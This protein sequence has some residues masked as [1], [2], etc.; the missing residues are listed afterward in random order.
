MCRRRKFK[1]SIMPCR[2]IRFVSLSRFLRVCVYVYVSLASFFDSAV[3]R[4]SSSIFRFGPLFISCYCIVTAS[5]GYFCFSACECACFSASF[6]GFLALRFSVA[7]FCLDSLITSSYCPVFGIW[8]VIAS[9]RVCLF[10]CLIFSFICSLVLS[11]VLILSSHRPIAL[12]LVFSVCSCFSACAWVC[13]SAS[14][15]SSFFLRLSGCICGLGPLFTSSHCAVT[16]FGESVC[17]FSCLSVLRAS[18]SRSVA[19]WFAGYIFSLNLLI[20]C[21]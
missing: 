14:F 11:F 21:S 4:I 7:I 9:F 20:K 8:C 3:F 13:F 6:S 12:L 1:S 16:T 5:G 17:F 2:R 19:L 10:S 18:F 15:S